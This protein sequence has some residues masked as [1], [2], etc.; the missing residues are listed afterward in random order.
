[1]KITDIKTYLVEAHRRNW[2]FIEVETDEGVTGVGEATIEPFERTMVTS[3]RTTSAQSSER[4]PT[5]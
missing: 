1:M 2:V 5:R 4:T 3:L